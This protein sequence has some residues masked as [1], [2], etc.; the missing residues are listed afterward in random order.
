MY[1]FL[2]FLIFIPSSASIPDVTL[3]IV[4]K[5][6]LVNTFTVSFKNNDEFQSTYNENLDVNGKLCDSSNYTS[7]VNDCKVK[8]E[9]YNSEWV[10]Q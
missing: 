4:S 3:K 10:F 2:I 6:A 5:Y 7:F 8:Y 1:V 9:G